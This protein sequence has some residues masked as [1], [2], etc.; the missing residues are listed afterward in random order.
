MPAILSIPSHAHTLSVGRAIY[1][2]SRRRGAC[3]DVLQL[4]KLI[5]L[6]HGWSLACTNEGL[7]D[8]PFLIG[9]CLGPV[10]C[11]LRGLKRTYGREELPFTAGDAIFG[12][13]CVPFG[14]DPT[15]FEVIARTVAKYGH[16]TGWKLS[17]IT[18][19]GGGAYER[20][21]AAG[22]TRLSDAEIRAD[23]VALAMA[24][25]KAAPSTA[26]A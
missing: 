18:R 17:A 13:A 8:E 26:N 19:M 11:S 12:G 5:Y 23:F 7:L 16:F 1:D 14:D 20:A 15:Q 21:I 22:V 10:L 24:G 4:E 3:L 9:D 25:R 2:A 6:S